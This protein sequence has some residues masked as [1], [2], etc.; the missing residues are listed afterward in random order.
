[1]VNLKIGD[2]FYYYSSHDPDLLANEKG[3]MNIRKYTVVGLCSPD[4]YRMEGDT[5]I[6]AHYSKKSDDHYLWTSFFGRTCFLELND[7]ITALEN[8]GYK[9]AAVE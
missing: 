9:L 7:A 3:M 4:I 8:D 2:V 6:I 5:Q 1:M